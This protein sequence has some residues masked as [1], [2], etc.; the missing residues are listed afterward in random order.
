MSTAHMVTSSFLPV[1]IIVLK[2]FII[3]G[4]CQDSSVMVKPKIIIG[5]LDPFDLLRGKLRQTG[6]NEIKYVNLFDNCKILYPCASH[7]KYLLLL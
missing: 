2:V 3:H 4:E 7:S 5:T 1:T 6:D